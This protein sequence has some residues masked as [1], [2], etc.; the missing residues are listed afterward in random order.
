MGQ[1]AYPR[2]GLSERTT[3]KADARN[4][5]PWQGDRP[6][7]PRWLTWNRTGARRQGCRSTSPAAPLERRPTFAILRASPHAAPQY[8]KLGPLQQRSYGSSAYQVDLHGPSGSRSKRLIVRRNAILGMIRVRMQKLRLVRDATRRERRITALTEAQRP[9]RGGQPRRGEG[10]SCRSP[11]D[12][13]RWPRRCRAP[14]G[15]RN[16]ACRPG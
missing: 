4:R 1:A 14:A 10:R 6:R 16:R 5:T 8:R 11:T 9:V 2:E 7:A 15:S 12:E 3:R 13:K